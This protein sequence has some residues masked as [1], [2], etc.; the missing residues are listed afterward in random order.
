MT[1][2][3]ITGTSSNAVNVA[4][5]ASASVTSNLIDATADN[6]GIVIGA[7]TD[8]RTGPGALVVGNRIGAAAVAGIR[9]SQTGCH[10][11]GNKVV[12]GVGTTANG[13]SLTSTA[14]G[15]VIT[16]NDLSGNGW[17]TSAAL[18]TSTALPVTGA[19]GTTAL[20]GSNGHGRRVEHH[21]GHGGH[22]R[23]H[24][25]SRSRSR[26]RLGRKGHALQRQ[27]THRDR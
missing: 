23:P 24:W 22:D 27:G 3:T 5:C 8:G 13:V 19:T 9:V 20:P 25:L 11:S 4:G 12:K 14:T 1:G 18:L 21:R 2:N 7:G 26:S 15:C 6:H 16:D 10:I 17:T